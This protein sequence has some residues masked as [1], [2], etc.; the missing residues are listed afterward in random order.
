MRNFRR[1]VLGLALV[2]LAGCGMSLEEKSNLA[3]ASCNVMSEY[4]TDD[5]ALRIKELNAA[6]EKIGQ[7]L[8]LEPSDQIEEALKYGLCEP[9]V[10]NEPDY[11]IRLG[12]ARELRAQR[13]SE[14][15]M[16]F[17]LFNH[18]DGDLESSFVLQA[19]FTHQNVI[20]TRYFIN[21]KYDQVREIK[22]YSLQLLDETRVLATGDDGEAFF[23]SIDWATSAL[24]IDNPDCGLKGG[25]SF[26]KAPQI[27]YEDIKGTWLT[28]NQEYEELGVWLTRYSDNLVTYDRRF[29]EQEKA[30]YEDSSE[31]CALTFEHGFLFKELCKS[32]TAPYFFFVSEYDSDTEKLTLFLVGDS[33][34]DQ[35]VEQNYE[36]PPPPNGYTKK[37]GVSD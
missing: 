29:F 3:I 17:W 31:T 25:C 37:K 32:A 16:G 28:T 34:I 8:F 7:P 27:A 35:R 10:L 19:E 33:V 14:F 1:L 9:L 4:A 26:K 30:T 22:T 13:S 2:S 21:E 15:L 11:D 18:S 20:L 6:R 23:I 24:K 5:G 36:F 12:A